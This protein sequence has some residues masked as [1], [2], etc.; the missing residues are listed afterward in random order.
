M[1]N[2]PEQK[3]KDLLYSCLSE[4]NKETLTFYCEHGYSL[5]DNRPNVIVSTHLNELNKV[6]GYDSVKIEINLIPGLWKTKA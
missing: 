6:H 4:A 2:T 3:V 5:R 1:E